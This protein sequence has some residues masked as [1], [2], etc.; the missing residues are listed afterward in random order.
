MPQQLQMVFTTISS[1]SSIRR[2]QPVPSRPV[3]KPA[4]VGNNFMGLDYLRNSR[5]CTACG[6][7]K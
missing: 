1:S 5:P 7:S 3:Y 6:H 2:S 4:Q